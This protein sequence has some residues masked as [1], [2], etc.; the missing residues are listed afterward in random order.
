MIKIFFKIIITFY[1]V[2]TSVM[3]EIVKD[4]EIS[5]NKRISKDTI[6]V[7]GKIKTG[8]NYDSDKLND[9]LKNLY[10]TN[11]FNNINLSIENQVLKIN[12][13]EKTFFPNSLGIFYHAMT[14]FL[15][16]KNFGEEYKMMGMAAYGSP[17]YFDKIKNNLF[18]KSNK[19][20]FRLNLD[21]FN[22]HK[23]Y[24]IK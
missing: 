13:I 19:H 23:I 5:G 20:L 1:F 18:K 21:Y 7:L 12:I 22:H 4:L 9:V 24:I 15:G 6:I 17:I 10:N 3:A 2:T 16:F 11:F 14:Q 8:E